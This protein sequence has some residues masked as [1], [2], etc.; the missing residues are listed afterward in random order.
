MIVRACCVVLAVG[1]LAGCGD[2][3]LALDR[4]EPAVVS[5]LD[6]TPIQLH[7]QGFVGVVQTAIDDD[8]APTVRSQFQILVGTFAIDLGNVQRIDDT[9]LGALVPAGLAPALY[10]VTIIAPDGRRVTRP[11]ALRVATPPTLLAE[12]SATPTALAVGQKSQVLT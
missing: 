2:R 6:S 10:D 7:G 3:P 12:A 4:V 8:R 11:A 9:T 1:V 5:A